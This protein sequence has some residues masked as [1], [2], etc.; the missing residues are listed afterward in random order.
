MALANQ[1]LYTEREELLQAFG[2]F[3]PR[4]FIELL[5]QQ[6]VRNLGVGDQAV[7]SLAC[8][9]FDV[10]GFTRRAEALGADRIFQL[11]N[12]IYSAV[13]PVLSEHGGIIDKYMGDGMMVLFPG[14]PSDAINAAEGVQR[15]V[16]ALNEAQSLQDDPIV[17]RS[18]ME[19]GQVILGTVGH[20]DRFDTTVIADPVNVASRLQS[21]CRTLRV[22]VLSTGGCQPDTPAAF[23]RCLGWFDIRGRA[24]PVALYEHYGSD[25][26]DTRAQ[27]E[28]LRSEFE[29]A[30]R[31]RKL[32]RWI[33]SVGHL[34]RC[35]EACPTDTA[36]QWLLTDSAVALQEK[37][38]VPT[39]NQGS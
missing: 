28:A 6:D 39:L 26:A 31:C 30:V 19:F 9:F 8:V 11:L 3:V 24:H 7:R 10:E 37:R 20:E 2:R 12:S 17:L 38:P 33:E 36:A 4:A 32:G 16:A 14:G 27:K 5:G 21:W 18:S 13:G 29:H 34:Q 35:I 15:A 23:T 25:P 22:S 1:R